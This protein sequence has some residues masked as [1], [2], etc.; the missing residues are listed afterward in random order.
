MQPSGRVGQTNLVDCHPFI[1]E[2]P[3][4]D[5]VNQQRGLE[6]REV[7]GDYWARPACL[8]KQ[9]VGFTVKIAMI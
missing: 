3:I 4:S 6:S 1:L 2:Q 7:H 5:E 8:R 9:G